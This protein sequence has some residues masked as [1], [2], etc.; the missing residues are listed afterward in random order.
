MK[1]IKFD[2]RLSISQTCIKTRYTNLSNCLLH[3]MTFWLVTHSGRLH[4]SNTQL[5]ARQK[6]TELLKLQKGLWCQVCAPYGY[7]LLSHL[8]NI[9]LTNEIVTFHNGGISSSKC[10][11]L[12]ISVFFLLQK[13][14][15]NVLLSISFQISLLLFIYSI[16][17]RKE[18]AFAS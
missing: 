18:A 12:I 16:C 7:V 2:K 5:R 6:K 8:G 11:T 3:I 1:K 17:F 15:I 9:V 4:L 10:A 14:M 13:I